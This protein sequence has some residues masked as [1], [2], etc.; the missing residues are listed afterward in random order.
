MAKGK[1]VP[2]VYLVNGVKMTL[3]RKDVIRRER[4]KGKDHQHI[5]HYRVNPQSK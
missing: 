1:V 3:T 4:R 2:G 5:E